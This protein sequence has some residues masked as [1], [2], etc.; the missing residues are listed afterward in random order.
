[1]DEEKRARVDS[2]LEEAL[3]RSGLERETFLEETSQEDEE[4][5][6][7]DRPSRVPSTARDPFC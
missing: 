1:M 5:G 7:E 3:S 6:R 4:I 2:L